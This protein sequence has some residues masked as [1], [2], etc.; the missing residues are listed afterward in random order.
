MAEVL[1][2]T[3]QRSERHGSKRKRG[4]ADDGNL[5]KRT[6]LEPHR[7]RPAAGGDV[8]QL[9]GHMT[10]GLIAD[11]IA[12]KIKRSF[13]DFSTVELEDKYLPQSIF[14][15]TSDFE[16]PRELD[17]LPSFL[18][19]YFT[20]IQDLSSSSDDPG[21]PHTLVIAASGLRAAD[22]T[23]F[24]ASISSSFLKTEPFGQVFTKIS[25][26]W[27]CCCEAVCQAY[28]IPRGCGICEANKVCAFRHS[29][30]SI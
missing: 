25:V 30:G 2:Q 10:P 12:K 29:I 11:H 9:I 3:T 15:D 28:Q 4:R 22:V 16:L 19:R 23:R 21:S 7:R 13:R 27:I 8:D 24:A 20:S 6:A 26:T 18:E 5:P 14:F 17:N 1:S